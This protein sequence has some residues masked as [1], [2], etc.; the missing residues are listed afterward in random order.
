MI[1]IQAL[2]IETLCLVGY[3]NYIR[4]VIYFSNSF[5][6]LSFYHTRRDG[7]RLAYNLARQSINVLNLSVWM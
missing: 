7:N 2:D 6:W 4:D 5:R 1:V 3:G